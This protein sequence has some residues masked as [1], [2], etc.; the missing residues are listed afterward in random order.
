M[1]HSSDFRLLSAMFL[2][3]C[4][5]LFTP[6]AW[7]G[8]PPVL[9]STKTGQTVLATTD[10]RERLDSLLT[11]TLLQRTQLGLMVY[12]LTA[13]S[14]VYAHNHQQTLRPASNEKIVTAITA[15]EVLGG[16]YLYTTGVYVTG[17]VEN[18]VLS[19]D[20]CVKAA[21]DPL[22]DTDDVRAL[23]RA[24]TEAGIRRIEG[25]LLCDN[26]LKDKEPYGSGW[27]WDDKNLTLDPALVGRK[28][29]LAGALLK[30]LK[31]EGIKITGKVRTASLPA[32]ARLVAVC[33]HG[34]DQILEPT[35]KRSD[36]LFAE[37]LF[38]HIG[39]KSGKAYAEK[40]EAVQRIEKLI[41]KLGFQPERYRIADGSG[42]SPYN[43]LS[44]EL[45]IAFLRY[46]YRNKSIYE[47][48]L[49]SMPVA[50]VDGTLKKR[51]IGTPAANNV[52]AK[53]GTLTGVITLSGYA[54]APNGHTLCF[55]IMNQGILRAADARNFQDRVCVAL[56][57]P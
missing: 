16:E 11:D 38:Y 43:Y 24:F 33:E 39:A 47:H 48:L 37:T 19:G 27:S 32:G 31:A 57:Q 12:D 13:D 28:P 54:T 51:M 50:G 52:R 42:L 53:T 40:K 17:K 15:L 46:A 49:P 18:G 55:S 41:R 29:G 56:T 44:P 21:F 7:A 14:V 1:K 35:M 22:L 6:N 34:I 23:A 25:N 4:I 5:L 45:L 10:L 26:T 30:A 2:V 36:N 20:V 8:N 3:A 9:S